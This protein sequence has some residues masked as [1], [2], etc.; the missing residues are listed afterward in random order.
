LF[1][2]DNTN[3]SIWMIDFGKTRPLSENI[4][5]THDREWQERN[6]EDGY[7]IG[8]NNLIDIFQESINELK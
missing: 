7:L 5:I 6:H 3:A 1:V 2:H 4:R 8:I